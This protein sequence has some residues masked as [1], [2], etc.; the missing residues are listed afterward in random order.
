MRMGVPPVQVAAGGGRA[1]TGGQ[2]IP[3][4]GSVRDLGS[5]HEDE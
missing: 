3:G 1:G 4:G 5:E 2:H